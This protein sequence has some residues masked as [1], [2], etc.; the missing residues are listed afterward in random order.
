VV[1]LDVEALQKLARW[2]L[3][4]IAGLENDL[5]QRVEFAQLGNHLFARHARHEVIEQKE[6]DVLLGQDSQC[7]DAVGRGEDVVPLAFEQEPRRLQIVR[8]V[9][10]EKDGESGG[11]FGSSASCH[12]P[13]SCT[14]SR[15]AASHFVRKVMAPMWAP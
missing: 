14:T 13:R 5:H 7:L 15:W 3:A 10:N 2:S 11:G 1:A 8:V 4:G 12:P 6:I 9:I